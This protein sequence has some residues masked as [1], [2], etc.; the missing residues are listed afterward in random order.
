MTG[1]DYT[2]ADGADESTDDQPA[3]GLTYG[4]ILDALERFRRNDI[5]PAALHVDEAG[6]KQLEQS[7]ETTASFEP[8]DG[9]ELPTTG[10]LGQV[11]GVNV[12][13]YPV[14]HGDTH[15]A[16]VGQLGGR[17]EIGS[18]GRTFGLENANEGE[19]DGA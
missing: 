6:R 14:I 3:P 16:L 11:N 18:G 10:Y 15:A 2:D 7:I 9:R 8:D 19:T 1:H 5:E 4:A 12:R 13:E 17:V